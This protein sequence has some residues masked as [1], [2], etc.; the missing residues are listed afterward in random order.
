[1]RGVK[2]V[3]IVREKVREQ[4]VVAEAAAHGHG[5]QILDLQ[6]NIADAPICAGRFWSVVVTCEWSVLCSSSAFGYPKCVLHQTSQNSGVSR[7]ARIFMSLYQRLCM[8][9]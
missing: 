1:M 7:F 8:Y 5:R 9:E 2:A 6:Y 4:L 3:V